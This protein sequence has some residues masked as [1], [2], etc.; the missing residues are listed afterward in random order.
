MRKSVL[1][2]KRK[3]D[4]AWQLV[5][6]GKWSELAQRV[7]HNSEPI[8]ESVAEIYRLS[9]DAATN[10]YWRQRSRTG[11]MAFNIEVPFSIDPTPAIEVK[12]KNVIWIMLDA[13]RQD[14]FDEY[15]K[16]GGLADLATN[17][18]YIPR[19]FAQGSWT[20]PSVFSFLTG[21]Y[22]FNCGVSRIVPGNDKL[23]S[24][25]A[26]FDDSCPTLFSVL[27]EQGYQVA[28]ILDGW[29]FT[30]RTTAG[31]AH[32]ED[33][34]FEETWGWIYGQ[35]RRHLS[36]TELRD[37]SLS[38]IQ[39]ADPARPF[40]LFV[41][42]LY[43]HSP[44]RGIFRSP[45]YV[46]SLSQKGWKFRIVEGFIKGL[47]LFESVYL[48]PLLTALTEVGQRD[49]TIIVLCSDH[50]DMFW[51]VEDD[52]RQDKLNEDDEIWRHQLEPYNALIKVPLLISGARMQ[53]VYSQPFRLMDVA[54]TL[55]EELGIK[56][57]TSQWDGIALHRNETRPVYADSAGYGYGGVAFQSEEQKLLMSHR[58]GAVS[59]DLSY[60]EY[61]NLSLRRDANG[62]VDELT[63]FVKQA[64]RRSD[65]I[66]E[67][68]N[69]DEE[70]L[71]RRLEALGYIE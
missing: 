58:L 28:S 44:Y 59:Y 1:S 35:G 47:Q 9:R 68:D 48:K 52:L 16:R 57:D 62:S 15:L 55:L 20:Y 22:P 41:R 56:Y 40:I 69:S 31:Q 37:A 4:R 64:S 2:V 33:K 3:S 27:R 70:V 32:R 6:Q 39:N 13:L 67:S 53:G 25:C 17:S 49:N 66:T 43:T 51:N 5:R 19:A 63:R 42:S 29:G 54:P 23:V 21:R 26:D 61:E 50:G 8:I 14:I 18:T 45:E 30:I 24:V 10:I 38:F 34:Y 60:D 65:S 36:L 71:M 46:T 7:R 11:R 12:R